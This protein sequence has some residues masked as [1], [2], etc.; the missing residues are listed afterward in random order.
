MS[1]SFLGLLTIALLV[2]K[3]LGVITIS[4]WLVFL[5]TMIG[6]GIS[7]VILTFIV[8]GIANYDRW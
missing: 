7:F 2:L 8:L 3:L 5:P 4:W 1:I 6:F